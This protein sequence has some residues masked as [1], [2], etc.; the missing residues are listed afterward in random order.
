MSRSGHA[1]G[2]ES[3]VWH[4]TP[5]S[6]PLEAAEAHKGGSHWRVEEADEFS[7]ID[8]SQAE[9]RQ[10]LKGAY[11]VLLKYRARRLSEQSQGG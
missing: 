5:V 11:R 6:S 7:Q 4:E 3:N 1:I 9:L 8:F 2:G 10:A